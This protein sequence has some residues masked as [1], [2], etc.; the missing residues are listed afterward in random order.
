MPGRRWQSMVA[1]A[2]VLALALV[3]AGSATAKPTKVLT[4]CPLTCKYRTP[5]KAINAAP[6]GARVVIRPGVYVGGVVVKGHKKDNLT[7]AGAGTSPRA[8]IL[9]GKGATGV[10]AQNGVY[11][12]GADHVTITNLWARN[13]VGNGY[14]VNA[15]HG[16]LM[17]NLIASFNR[18]YGLYAFKSIGGRMTED[19][20]Y[21]HGDSGYYVGGTPIQAKPEP[22]L[23]D[24]VKS[25]ENVLG[26]S[27]TNCHYVT[28]RNSEFFNNGAG[29]APNTLQ[30]EPY[31]PADTNTITENLVFWNNFDYYKPDSPVKALPS[32][33][34]SFNYPIG[35]GI[36][37]FGV[38]NTTVR[39]NTVFGNF[40]WG[41]ASFEDPTYGPATN[42]GN[43]MTFNL[44][45]A[46]ESDTNG[47]DFFTDGNGPGNCWEN[48][49]A[50]ATFDQGS[51]PQA[52]LYP[53]CSAGTP[54][55]ADAAQEAKL[56]TYAT[57]TTGQEDSWTKHPHP[58]RPGVKPIDGQPTT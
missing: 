21:G 2:L 4:V 22:T 49:S 54:E 19:I 30:S 35:V 39:A 15:V 57:Q 17:K 38:H 26:Y 14:F 28:I 23:I 55:T 27:G 31:G 36:V 46:A 29:I 18:A 16:Y 43:K 37:L 25:Y 8:T 51:Q 48:N 13:F 20:A 45:G 47:A 12:D 7:I 44:M 41:I 10:P 32:A 42:V 9:E 33:V 53:N 3:G 5:Q 1:G 24:H 50:G 6:A 40:K 11:V 52:L 56:G 58:A 34:G